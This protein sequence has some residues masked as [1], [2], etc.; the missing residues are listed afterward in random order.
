[1]CFRNREGKR[2][3]KDSALYDAFPVKSSTVVDLK[4]SS[5]VVDHG[6]LLLRVKWNVGRKLSFICEQYITYLIKHY[7]ENCAVVFQVY[8]NMNFT[9]RQE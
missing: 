8:G 7:S 1:M 9:K 5:N 4:M 3:T 2:K 6:F